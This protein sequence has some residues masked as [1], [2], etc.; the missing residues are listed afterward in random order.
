MS[1][2]QGM[3]YSSGFNYH[4]QYLPQDHYGGQL[5]NFQVFISYNFVFDEITDLYSSE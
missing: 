5:S 3:R 2:D 4:N 1:L